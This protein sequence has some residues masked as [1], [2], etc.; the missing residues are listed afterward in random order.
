MLPKSIL[1]V[2]HI[3][4]QKELFFQNNWLHQDNKLAVF[5]IFNYKMHINK[6]IICRL[7]IKFN[8]VKPIH[9]LEVENARRVDFCLDIKRKI[10]NLNRKLAVYFFLYKLT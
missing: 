2:K 4:M 7:L 3:E 9:S 5:L 1:I 10:G 8:K 6:F